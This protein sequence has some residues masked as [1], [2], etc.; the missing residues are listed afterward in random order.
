MAPTRKLLSLKQKL[1]IIK[2]VENSSDSVVY[3]LCQAGSMWES[4]VLPKF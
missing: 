2:F 1:E 4:R 3:V